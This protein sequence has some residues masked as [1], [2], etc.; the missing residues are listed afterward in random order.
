[1][2]YFV[3]ALT[4]YGVSAFHEPEPPTSFLDPWWVG[5]V[6]LLGAL[7]WRSVVTF[8]A[9][10]AEAAYWVW[11]AVSFAPISQV[12]PFLYPMADRYLYFI[13]PGLIGG[14]LLCGHELLS[15][16]RIARLTSRHPEVLPR[17][18]VAVGVIVLL[19]FAGQS[20]ARARIWRSSAFL[21]ADSARNY[22]Q[23]VSAHLTRAAS[24][25]QRG[26][27]DAVVAN[28]RGAV[29]RGY[30]QFQQLDSDP[31][32]APV[33]EHPKFRAVVNDIA[34]IRI[35]RFAAKK[36]PTQLELRT[37]A[38]AYAIRGEVRQARTVLERALEVGGP[39]D[40]ETRADLAELEKYLR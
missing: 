9:R 12:F 1:M 31:A 35:Q 20:H 27:V 34:L 18:L 37:V 14:A 39:K 17:G 5:S 21:L 11:A 38:R 4:S 33:R 8:R 13:L 26:N 24:A 3:M 28:L 30:L 23:G 2:R 16:P 10:K 36:N 6:F 15:V 29:E 19:A 22:P 7:G 40:A 25:A 32:L